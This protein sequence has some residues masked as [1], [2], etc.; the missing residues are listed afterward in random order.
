MIDS[1]DRVYCPRYTALPR[2]NGTPLVHARAVNDPRELSQIPQ[3]QNHSLFH[4]LLRLTHYRM[5]KK[6]QSSTK[7]GQWLQMRI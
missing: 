7:L 1:A 2:Q 5:K 3:F 4:M 6:C